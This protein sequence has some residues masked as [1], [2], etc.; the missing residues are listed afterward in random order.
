MCQLQNSEQILTE[1]L[2]AWKDGDHFKVK[3]LWVW[4]G[5][6]MGSVTT[7]NKYQLSPSLLVLYL[8]LT[9]LN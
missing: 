7:L 5:L 6:G 2:G 1:R 8:Y 9:T 4:L 3:Q